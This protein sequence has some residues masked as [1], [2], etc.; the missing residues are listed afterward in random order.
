M[1]N[2]KSC[3]KTVLALN[4]EVSS[5]F[6]FYNFFEKKVVLGVQAFDTEKYPLMCFSRLWGR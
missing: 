4:L 3:I 5:N 2:L 1:K 6:F